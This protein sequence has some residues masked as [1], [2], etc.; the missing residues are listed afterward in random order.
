MNYSIFT[1]LVKISLYVLILLSSCRRDQESSKTKL[2]DNMIVVDSGKIGLVLPE[3]S[4]KADQAFSDLLEEIKP[5]TIFVYKADTLLEETPLFWLFK[6]ISDSIIPMEIV[7]IE[8]TVK[9]IPELDGQR[10]RL[11]DFGVFDEDGR[12][13][14]YKFTQPP[15]FERKKFKLMYFFM[16]NDSAYSLYEL[17]IIFDEKQYNYADS[18]LFNIAESFIFLDH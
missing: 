17:G 13:Y 6:S 18:V 9:V 15:P 14:R 1:G 10:S 4:Q 7:F 12:R 11:I 16:E 5:G 8:H 2:P 3:R